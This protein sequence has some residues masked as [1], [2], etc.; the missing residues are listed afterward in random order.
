MRTYIYTPLIL[1]V[2]G[3]VSAW[4]KAPSL[5]LFT[6]LVRIKSTTRHDKYE[7]GGSGSIFL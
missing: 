7:V 1:Y 4:F 3:Q 5:L 2:L 6:M